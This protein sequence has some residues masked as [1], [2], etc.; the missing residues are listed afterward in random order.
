MKQKVEFK[1]TGIAIIKGLTKAMKPP[2]EDK[3]F[4]D[5]NGKEYRLRKCATT[6]CAHGAHNKVQVMISGPTKNRLEK[7]RKHIEQQTG[8]IPCYA[9]A[10][11]WAINEVCDQLGL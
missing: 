6:R 3:I 8:D 2:K 9:E 5:E 11:D 4:V 10:V 1:V 7:L